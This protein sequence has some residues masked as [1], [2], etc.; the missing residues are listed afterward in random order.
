[1]DRIAL[2]KRLESFANVFA[3]HTP[4]NRDLRAMAHVISN[5][6]E[7]RYSSIL[8]EGFVPEIG[9]AGKGMGPGMGMGPGVGMK[10]G[11]GLG[12]G[13]PQQKAV[14]VKIEPQDSDEKSEDAEPSITEAEA[15]KNTESGLETEEMSSW[16]KSASEAVLDSLVRDVVAMDKKFDG[17]S[18]AK[19]PSEQIPDNDHKGLPETPKELKDEQTPDLGESYDSGMVDKS[20]IKGGV[21]KEAQD[22]KKK[23]DPIAEIKEMQAENLEGQADRASEKADKKKKEVEKILEKAEKADEKEKVDK[24]SEEESENAEKKEVEASSNFGGIE[25][26]PSMEEINPNSD[27]IQKLSQ[28]FR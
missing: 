10:P 17:E 13:A 18:N 5:M 1:M 28:L 20:K 23:S 27:E 25:L 24:E 15:C 19:L 8:S 14:V 7:E 21:K 9:Y 6:D 2:S 4:M 16:D 22:E 11:K 26:C 3:S 12:F